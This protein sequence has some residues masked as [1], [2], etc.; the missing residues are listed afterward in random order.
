LRLQPRGSGMI[1]IA[2]DKSVGGTITTTGIMGK[3]AH[4][5]E[6][7]IGK[8]GPPIITLEKGGRFRRRAASNLRQIKDDDGAVL[9]RA[10]IGIGNADHNVRTAEPAGIVAVGGLASSIVTG[11]CG[12]LLGRPTRAAR[13]VG[14]PLASKA[15]L[16]RWAEEQATLVPHLFGTPEE[17]AA[18]AQNIRLCGG[19][20]GELPIAKYRG[21]WVSAKQVEMM[22]LPDYIVFVDPI[23]IEFELKH[24]DNY[25]PRGL[26]V[27][28]AV[29][30]TSGN[31]SGKPESSLSLDA[32]LDGRKRPPTDPC[33]RRHRGNCEVL[34]GRS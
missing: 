23:T 3:M 18:C 6:G 21:D 1:S 11:I 33:R 25:V 22:T 17:R 8:N 10:C 34:G 30:W 9:G 28:H 7:P 24:V 12:V 16:K 2:A 27:R 14:E 29:F 20:T 5:H 19:N 13:D 26:R 31:V 32:W 4:I 15:A